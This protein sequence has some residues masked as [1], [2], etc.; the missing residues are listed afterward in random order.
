MT[1][2]AIVQERLIAAPVERV[3]A[4]WTRAESLAVWMG[5]GPEFGA[6]SVTLDFRVGGAFEIVMHGEEDF[7]QTG[8]YVEIVPN[9]RLVMTWVSH[10]VAE[11]ETTTC[12]TVRFEAV[13]NDKTRLR[14]QHD[15]PESDTYEGHRDG[16][17]TIVDRFERSLEA[18]RA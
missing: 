14:L 2:K 1:T 12:V 11:P 15:V 6:A 4:A 8:E 5:P 9:E 18:S 13:G 7:R 10:W 17:R 16:W 3:Y